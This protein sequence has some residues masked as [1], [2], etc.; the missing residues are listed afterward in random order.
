MGSCSVFSPPNEPLKYSTS[1]GRGTD[2]S[3]SSTKRYHLRINT[4]AERDATDW[5]CDLSTSAT[6]S[7]T[8]RL[9]ISSGPDSITF[10]PPSPGPVAEGESLT[11]MCAASCNPPCSYSWT[12]RN[13][14]ISSTSQL[15]LASINRSQTESVYTCNATNSFLSKSETEQF[16]L[17]VNLFHFQSNLITSAMAAKGNIS[18]VEKGWEMGGSSPCNN[19]E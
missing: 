15:T 14:P 9:Q 8:F 18:T 16:T 7:N 19:F 10:S 4:A 2:S 13:Q 5:W 17:T 1:C 12:L 11:V 6:R 3:S